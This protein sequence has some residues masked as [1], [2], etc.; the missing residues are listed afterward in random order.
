MER[1]SSVDEPI[2]TNRKNSQIAE[3]YKTDHYNIDYPS[4]DPKRKI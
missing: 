4:I 2:V 3:D 1:K